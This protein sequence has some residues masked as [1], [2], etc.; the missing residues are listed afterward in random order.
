MWVGVQ[1]VTK[2]KKKEGMRF[3]KRG[4]TMDGWEGRRNRNREEK[5]EKVNTYFKNFQI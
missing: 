3:M 5:R 2:K 1:W 4:N